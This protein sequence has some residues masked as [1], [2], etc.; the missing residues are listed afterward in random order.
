MEELKE[1]LDKYIKLTEKALKEIKIKGNEKKANEILEL[2][3]CY[4]KDSL[5][6]KDKNDLVN[7]FA[8]INYSHAFLDIGA[9]LGLFTIKDKKL[10]M[11]E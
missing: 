11:V 1:K 2:S 4:Y 5:F 7:A 8:A 10:L 3:K 9:R 6:F